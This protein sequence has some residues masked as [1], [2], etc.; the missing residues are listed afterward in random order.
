MTSPPGSAHSAPDAVVVGAGPNGLAAAVVLARAGLKVQVLEAA[1]EPG[2][3]ARTQELI[4]PGHWHDV[5]SAVHPLA[6]ASPFFSDFG[7]AERI[8]LHTPEISYAQVIDG[9]DAAIAYRSLARTAA[10]LGVDGRAYRSLLEPLVQGVDQLLGLTMNQLLRLPDDPVAALKFGL[11]V[12]EQGGPLWNMRFKEYHAPALLTGVAAHTPG[13]PRRL[14]GAGAGLMLGALAHAVGYP[15]PAGGSKA[16]IEALVADLQ[17]HGGSVATGVRVNDMRDLP[18]AR[19][20]LLDTTPQHLLRLA[21]DRLPAGYVNTLGR[22][23]YGPGAAKVDYILSG[24]VPWA[25]P[26]LAKAATVHL[27]GTR[28]QIR[29]AEQEVARGRHAAWP[30]TLVAQPSSFDPTRAPAGRHV[31]WTYCHVPN[32]SDRDLTALI[33]TQ[34]EQA[35]PGFADL[36]VA[37]RS[38]SAADYARYNPNYAGGD[39]GTGAVSLRQVLARPTLRPQPWHTPLKGF[40]LC[41]SA[42]PPGPGVHGMSGYHAASLALQEV[43]GLPVPDLA[44]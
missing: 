27:G 2:G 30:F 40:Y 28:E 18:A 25:N 3:G 5:C 21:A 38:M 16:I 31:L 24:P 7:L 12:L 26:E 32:G 9:A 41:S 35:A 17:A 19:A 14:V 39:F 13:G 8:R 1:A 20:V 37:S 6:V 23:R 22:Y 43:F 36:V 29:V 44:P 11:R 34:L 15:L 4:E 10:G 42:T 33:T